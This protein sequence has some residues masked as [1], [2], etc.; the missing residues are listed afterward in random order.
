ME[1]RSCSFRKKSDENLALTKRTGTESG[2]G[3][4]QCLGRLNPTI[5]SHI[6]V[7]PSTESGSMRV[8]RSELSA[9]EFCR[10]LSLYFVSC[11]GTCTSRIVRSAML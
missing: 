3:L 4:I 7:P 9:L 11:S 1:L 10:I 8:C 2:E 5:W 6:P